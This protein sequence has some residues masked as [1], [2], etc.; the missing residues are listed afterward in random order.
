MFILQL[1]QRLELEIERMKQMHQKELEDK[2]EELEDVRQ[3]CQKRVGQRWGGQCSPGLPLSMVHSWGPSSLVSG[4]GVRAAFPPAWHEPHHSPG[5]KT[6]LWVRGE[7]LPHWRGC[8][9]QCA[10]ATCDAACGHGALGDTSVTPRA[11]VPASQG[12]EFGDNEQKTL[13]Q[14]G[15]KVSGV[16]TWMRYPGCLIWGCGT[17]W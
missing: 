12:F 14:Q 4:V 10:T 17:V 1:H 9:G 13:F 15:C 7:S 2:D 8:C 3:S 5:C 16:Q 11:V 6:R